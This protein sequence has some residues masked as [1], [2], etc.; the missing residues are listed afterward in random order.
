[1]AL[2]R[3][4]MPIMPTVN[5]ATKM[6][7]SLGFNTFLSIIIAGKDSAVTDIIN[8]KAV[9]KD[10]PF[11]MKTATNGIIPAALEYKGTPINT[12]YG[13]GE[14]IVRASILN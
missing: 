3:Y 7:R 2:N 10:I 4:P 5:I 11:S 12:A 8:A 13:N 9:P 14:R 1:M 6:A